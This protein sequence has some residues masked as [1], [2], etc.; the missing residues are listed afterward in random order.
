[1]TS[2]IPRRSEV[3]VEDRWDTE[4]IFSSL[5]AW[6]EAIEEV[7]PQLERLSNYE[8][9]LGNG[10][11]VLADYLAELEEM[12]RVVGRIFVY[13]SL[14]YSV[15]MAAQAA[16]ARYDRARQLFTRARAA[17]AFAEPE[18]VAIGEETLQQWVGEEPRLAD[19]GHYF[20]RLM[21][22]R[23]HLRSAEIETLL[24][25]T[26]DAF[27]TATQTHRVLVDGELAFEPAQP[28]DGEPIEVMQSNINALITHED[29]AIRRTAW[30]NYADAYLTY[31]NT[32]ANTL[33]A[34]MKQDV[35]LARARNYD[36]SL[37]ASLTPN[38][39][40]VE[41]FHNTID[42][43]KRHL[44]LWHRYWRVRRQALGYDKLHVYDI[45]APLTDQKP[46]VPFDQA[47][48]WISEGMQPLGDEYV[49]AM[50]R[51][52]L[53]ERWVDKYPNVGKRSGAFSS[54]TPGTHPFIFMSYTDDLFSLSTLAHELGH[55]M[56]SYFTWEHQ[57][58]VYAR[59]GLFVA[60]VASNFNQALVRGHLLESH[61]EDPAFQIAVLEEAMSNFH[62]Y[63]FIMPTLARFELEIHERVEQGEALPADRLIDLMTSLFKEG[64]GDEVEIDHDRIGITWAQFPNHIYANFYVYQYTTGI[65][66][67]HAL[68]QRVQQDGA[69]AAEDYLNF[70]KAGGSLYPLEAL[71]L[72]GVD[73]TSPEPVDAAFAVL[74]QYVDRLEQLTAAV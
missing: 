59:Y 40:P 13:A 24:K 60:E 71:R 12:M 45:K 20:D 39:I 74:E 56:H 43:F 25:Q 55:S 48:D 19:Y 31:K 65:A 47:V 3:P 23:S 29:R 69:A 51:G 33:S 52:V 9:H 64:Y 34:G 50:R 63:F 61:E 7:Q 49:Q 14:N 38:N 53:Q 32:L 8:G 36:S 62:R 42:V 16:A 1:M 37:A 57:P 18:L 28:E 67:A 44:P 30:E 15:D 73:M 46:E 10:P 26:T 6:E 11:S 70:L 2:T 66:A 5:D 21:R 4:M 58:F 72:A 68:A 22:R 54:G 35:F 41:V 17:T 27:T